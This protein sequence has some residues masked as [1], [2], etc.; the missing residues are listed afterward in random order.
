VLF[1]PLPTS[2]FAFSERGG[3]DRYQLNNLK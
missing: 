3:A 1:N 2:P